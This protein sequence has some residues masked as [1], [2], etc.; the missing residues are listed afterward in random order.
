MTARLAI[1]TCCV[2]ACSSSSEDVASWSTIFSDLDR[3]AL[4]AW[5][6]RSDDVYIV[7]GGLDAPGL[8]TLAL[9]WD[10]QRWRDLAPTGEHTLW[11]VTGGRGESIDVWMVGDAGTVLRWDGATFTTIA[12]PVGATLFGAWVAAPDDVWI[13]GGVPGAGAVTDNDVLLHW[14]G[15][16]LSRDTTLPVRGVALLKVWGSGADDLWIVGEQGVLWHHTP[17]GWEDHSEIASSTLFSVYGCG[18]DDIY[19]VG[20]PQLL[21]YDGTAWSHVGPP[22]YGAAVGVACASDGVLVTGSGGLKL[23]WDRGS[24]AWFDDQLVAPWDA[25]FHAAWIDPDGGEWA[26]GGNYNQAGVD[27]SR[28]GVVAYYG[29]HP[30]LPAGDAP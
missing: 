3:V 17:L 25:D 12:S 24:D 13:V 28:V 22:I 9:H 11:W 26:V 20:G 18:R 2:A 10:G 14:D 7:G 27:D 4:S 21:H 19:A 1:A 30:P 8:A 6:E 15:Q 5:S 29:A 23:R 16:R